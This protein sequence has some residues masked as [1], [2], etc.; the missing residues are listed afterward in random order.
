MTRDPSELPA[1]A[2]RQAEQLFPPLLFAVA[3]SYGEAD[4]PALHP[5]E[6]AALRHI[7]AERQAAFQRGR[8]C[9][10]NALR[11]IGAGF[12]PV[13]PDADGAPQWPDGYTGSIAHSASYSIAA[14]ARRQDVAAVGVKV[15]AHAARF[16]CAGAEQLFSRDETDW[17][18]AL[19]QPQFDLHAHALACAKLACLKAMLAVRAC[20]APHQLVLR[21]DLVHGLFRAE[22]PPHTAMPR[23][24]LGRIACDGRHVYAGVWWP[25][26][27]R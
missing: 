13:P 7:P 4:A 17:L 10:R 25:Q 3:H 2:L 26:A 14:C 1:C 19:P 12:R 15:R 11:Q 16:D 20:A 9:S 23:R 21:L 8:H 27:A 24:L 6:A 18:A 22:L 5:A